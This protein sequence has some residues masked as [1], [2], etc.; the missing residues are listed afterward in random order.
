MNKI[1]YV[2]GGEKAQGAEIVLE[3]M[4]A[5]N[6]NL[7]DAHLFIS[8]GRFASDIIAS[9]KSYK[10]SLL[11]ALKKLNRSKNGRLKSLFN[12][13]SNYIFLSY[14]VHRYLKIND[15]KIIHANTIM[16]ASYLIPVIAYSRIF[17]RSR[18]WI[19]SDHDI[20][21]YSRFEHQLSKI[22]A[23]VYD[24][25][26]AV[27]KPVKKKYRENPKVFVLYNGLDISLFKA[28]PAKRADFREFHGLPENCLIL[29][30][31]AV[32][33]E[34]KGQLKLIECF[35]VIAKP[36]L[37]VILL[38]AGGFEEAT[39]D[40]S[41]AFFTAIAENAQIRHIGFI[42]DMVSFYNGCDIIISNSNLKDSEPLGTTIYEAMAC[43]KIVVASA[44]G[45]TPEIIN[46]QI[47]GFLFTPDSSP[48]LVQTLKAV[49]DDFNSLDYVRKAA[50]KKV[51]VKFNVQIMAK[52]YNEL[53][54][55]NLI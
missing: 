50:R 8:P 40:Y 44:T 5:F 53:I 26:L 39:P 9:G 20:T 19:W 49:I 48:A 27:S 22:C 52:T 28:D 38:F 35:K 15:I 33:H 12:A 31:P 11:K 13:M 21:Y 46:N 24:F 32:V 30:M 2:F 18:K 54:F 41:E 47:D 34:R 10:I 45:G 51:K 16:P 23:K 43:E 25:T 42:N 4:M 55:G 3:R 14:Q 36:S 29:G 17:Y 1:L 37:N 7:V 6:V